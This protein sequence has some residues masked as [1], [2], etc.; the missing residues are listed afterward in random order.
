MGS[1]KRF[2]PEVAPAGDRR[3]TAAFCGFCIGNPCVLIVALLLAL[4]GCATTDR[5]AEEPPPVEIPEST[6]WR[7]DNDIGAASQA[8]TGPAGNYARGAMESWRS[9]VR[10]RT[11]ADFIPWFTGYWTQQ[12]LAIKVAWYKLGAEE[13]TDPAVDRLAAYLQEQYDERVLEPVARE[14]DPDAVRGEATLLYIQIV[15]E[16]LP[17][18]RRRHGVPQARFDQRLRNIPAIALAPPPTHSASLYQIVNADPIERLPAYVA[19]IARFG[20]AAGGADAGPAEARIS[21]VAKRASEGMVARLGPAVGASAA[22][23]VVGGVAGV[24]ISLGAAGFGAIAHEKERP[25]IEA[26]LRESLDAALGDMWLNLMED[27]AS[28]VLAGVHHISGQI[29][30]ALSRTFAQPVDLEPLPQEIPLS[31]QLAPDDAESGDE[32]TSDR[33]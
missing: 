6:W 2:Y 12:W 32:A 20:K 28:G 29:E 9:H 15:G 7:V 5:A 11:E 13:G 26:L 4:A 17:G 10:A 30:G 18:I 3:P 22:A 14:I 31:D 24:A 33:R 19:L 8:A 16:Q 25:E 23:A 1:L 21:P 27:P